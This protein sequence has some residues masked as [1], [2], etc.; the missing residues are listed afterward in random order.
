MKDLSFMSSVEGAVVTLPLAIQGMVTGRAQL[1][2]RVM[3]M[4]LSSTADPARTYVV[5]ILQDVGRSN[6]RSAEDLVNDFT[7]AIA[8]VREVITTEQ[9]LRTDL[10]TDEI[11]A[12]IVTENIDV[13][14]DKVSA[15]IQIIT[16]SGED[17]KV[18]LEI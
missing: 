5:G 17:L 3:T 14:G 9:A 8:T 2:Q 6:V 18:S 1:A 11:L 15:D 7:L 10:A 12:D 13:T 16:E 4:L